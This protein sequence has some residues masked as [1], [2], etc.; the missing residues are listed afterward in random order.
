MTEFPGAKESGWTPWYGVT[1]KHKHICCDCELEH[2]VEQR[3]LP[4]G[5]IQERWKR[6]NR[7]TANRRRKLD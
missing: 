7:A 6:D 3:I 4:D 2:F 5:T 1:R